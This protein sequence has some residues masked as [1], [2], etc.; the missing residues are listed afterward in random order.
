MSSDLANPSSA[1]GD[2]A[3]RALVDRLLESS[4]LLASPHGTI[5][6]WEAPAGRLYGWSADEAVGRSVLETLGLESA[7]TGDAPSGVEDW[8]A[9]FERGEGPMPA[10]HAE[11]TAR[12]RDGQEFRAELTFVPIPLSEG[13]DFNTFLHELRPERSGRDPLSASATS[14][15][16]CC[17]RSPRRSEAIANW[18]TSGSP[19]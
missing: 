8:T 7:G 16:W 11:V 13:L 12:H 14:T 17:A 2:R 1:L 5:S 15:S 9:V 6:R 10:A 19:A 4:F 18:R 3:T